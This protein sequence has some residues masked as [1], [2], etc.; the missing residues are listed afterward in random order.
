MQL[1][2]RNI[3]KG[4]ATNSSSYHSTIVLTEEEYNKWTKG[5][6]TIEN[7]WGDEVTYDEWGGEY[8]TDTTHYTSPSGDKLVIIC[9]HGYNG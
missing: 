7:D 2:L 5:E 8:E 1:Y 3:K 4:F 6:I 9:E